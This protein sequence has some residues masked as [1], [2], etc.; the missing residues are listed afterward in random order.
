[1]YNE[2]CNQKEGSR[3]KSHE[4]LLLSRWV[5]KLTLHSLCENKIT[6]SSVGQLS[7]SILKLACLSVNI[8]KMVM[9]QYVEE[10]SF[11]IQ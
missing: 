11:C 7:Y 2:N 1:M 4:L 5:V 3:H 10:P 8:I 9:F 6:S